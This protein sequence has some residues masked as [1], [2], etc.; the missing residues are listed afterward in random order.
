MEHFSNTEGVM[1]HSIESDP[2]LGSQSMSRYCASN[3]QEPAPKT[4]IVMMAL[5]FACKKFALAK[6][7]SSSAA[8]ESRGLL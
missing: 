7:A 8:E 4:A 3:G 2:W 6:A 1:L 5:L